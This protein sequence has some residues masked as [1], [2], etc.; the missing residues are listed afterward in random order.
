[1]ASRRDCYKILEV[2][3]NA[4][5]EDIRKSFRKLAMEW[6]PDKNKDP[7]A[8]KK[9]K[10]INAAYQILSD[11]EKRDKYDR[12]GYEGL[13]GDTGS[14]GF[15][16]K[17]GFGEIFDSFFGGFDSRGG[18]KT[19]AGG[20]IYKDVTLTFQEAA[21]GVEKDLEMVRSEPCRR[22]NGARSEP[23]TE[24]GGCS[25]CRGTG[26]V[27]R[28]SQSLFGQFVQVTTCNV[29]K[30]EGK[31]ITEPCNQCK[32][33]GSESHKRTVKVRIPAGIEDG[34]QIRLNDQG[35]YGY[36]NRPLGSLYLN[37]GVSP[38][39]FFERQEDHLVIEFPVTFAQ[40][41][42]GD[43]LKIP[44]LNGAESLKLP[45]GTQSGTVLNLRGKGIANMHTGRMG[46]L[47]VVIRVQ[48]PQQLNSQSKKLF[49]QLA[50]LLDKEARD[51]GWFD[52]IKDAL[53]RYHS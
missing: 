10:E 7:D 40:A 41:A 4:S 1:M 23:G 17:Q 2:P 15:S 28:S 24:A 20:D 43:E 50:P 5:E 12:Y 51:K 31:V 26:Q 16:E 44:T 48:T 9:F 37:V 29:C 25:N 30:G 14:Q 38:H 45:A 49:E 18:S 8:E 36:G 42:I 47:L 32:G 33:S 53:G 39:S 27:R 6:H 34:T 13:I 11:Q 19:R 35:D 21:L 46:N 3:R 22:C 52:K